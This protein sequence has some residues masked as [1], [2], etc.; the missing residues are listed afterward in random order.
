M[1]CSGMALQNCWGLG[2]GTAC[3][4]PASVCPRTW[5]ALGYGYARAV[6]TVKAWLWP[7]AMNTG[8]T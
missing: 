7:S 8:G 4:H 3:L 5:A 1:P 2:Y 6:F